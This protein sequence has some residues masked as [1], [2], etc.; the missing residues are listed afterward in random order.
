[1]RCVR[2]C[3]SP[4]GSAPSLFSRGYS[5]DAAPREP[6]NVSHCTAARFSATRSW[7]EC[8]VGSGAP[9]T[10]SR[11]KRNLATVE[12]MWR[13]EVEAAHTYKQLAERE[14]NPKRRDIL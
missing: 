8:R 4:Q 7:R 3:S 12:T 9:V 10:M 5:D 1:M 11:D 13:R 14:H 6:W 2:C